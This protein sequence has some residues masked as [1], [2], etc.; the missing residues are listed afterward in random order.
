LAILDTIVY[1]AD[2]SKF[3]SNG[4]LLIGDEIV[5]YY[6][7]L[8]DRFLKV[9]RG[10]SNTIAKAWSAGTFILQI[11]DPISTAFGG[12]STIES[13][14]AVSIVGISGGISSG[15]GQAS[16]RQTQLTAP[17]VTLVSSER[18]IELG[19]HPQV[20]IDSV[21]DILY[22]TRSSLKHSSIR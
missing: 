6:R 5:R 9:E 18:F 21:I 3:K 20:A 4:Y 22:I 7:K 12:V 19:V 15:A 14:S 2:T 16:T 10:Q 1:I 8:S 13:Q 11:P 17:A